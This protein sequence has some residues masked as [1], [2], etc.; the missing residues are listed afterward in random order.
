MVYKVFDK[1][2]GNQDNG[3]LFL[4]SKGYSLSRLSNLKRRGLSYHTINLLLFEAI[5]SNINLQPNDFYNKQQ[6]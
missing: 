6:E 1:L 2:F 5:K 4:K 3:W